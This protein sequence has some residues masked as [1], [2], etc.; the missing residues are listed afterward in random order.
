M[1]INGKTP[2]T[3]AERKRRKEAVHSA[4]ASF[5]LSGFTPSTDDLRHEKSFI[6]GEIDLSEFVTMRL[7]CAH[8]R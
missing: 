2:I 8:A 3:D 6:D 7:E 1:S 4:R 5:A